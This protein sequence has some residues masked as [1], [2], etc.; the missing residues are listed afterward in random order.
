MKAK[1]WRRATRHAS[2][3]S[4]PTRLTFIDLFAGCGGLALGFV[5]EGLEPVAAVEWD[6]AAAETY[7]LNID[8]TIHVR[9]IG[10]VHNLPKTDVVIGGPPCQGFSQ[11]GARD[12][13][14][15]RNKLWKEY[16]RV[17]AESEAMVFV[18]EN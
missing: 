2:R 15:L 5:Q 18:M 6:P 13:E 9:D 7:A 8:E 3:E 4:E 17:L 16:V 11:L 14:D 10:L 12:P 1:S